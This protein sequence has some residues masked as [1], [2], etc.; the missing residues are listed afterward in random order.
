[1]SARGLFTQNKLWLSPR[2][3]LL[4]GAQRIRVPLI[5]NTSAQ[6]APTNV[7]SARPA[8]TV[9]SRVNDVHIREDG[10]TIGTDPHNGPANGSP[11]SERVRTHQFDTYRL[12]LALQSA[13][14]SRPQAVALMKCLRTVL[15]NGTE[16]AKSHYLFRGDLE[17]VTC[18]W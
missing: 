6:N 1:M 17:N 12:V 5:R 18:R 10:D 15:V 4:L 9:N 8:N 13:G 14:Y 3:V 11:Y 2:R 7:D 16:F